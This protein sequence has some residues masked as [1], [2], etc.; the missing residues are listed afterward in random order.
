MSPLFP[1]FTG[2]YVIPG[3]PAGLKRKLK[4]LSETPGSRHPSRTGRLFLRRASPAKHR[5][6][7]EMDIENTELG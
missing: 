6:I 7:A 5:A 1:L 3:Q 4:V 2:E